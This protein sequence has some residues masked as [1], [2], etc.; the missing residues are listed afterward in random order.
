MHQHLEVRGIFKTRTK[1]TFYFLCVF[2]I[3]LPTQLPKVAP[4]LRPAYCEDVYS[5]GVATEL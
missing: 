3:Y 5:N 1:Y 4:G 2:T